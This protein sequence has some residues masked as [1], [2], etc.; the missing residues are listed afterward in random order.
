MDLDRVIEAW[1]RLQPSIRDAILVLV[2]TRMTYATCG[3]TLVGQASEL[4][5]SE[6]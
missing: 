6:A 5:A 2:I 1:P 4:G 3:Q